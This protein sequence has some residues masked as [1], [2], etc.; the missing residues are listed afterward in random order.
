MAALVAAGGFIGGIMALTNLLKND[1]STLPQSDIEQ[2]NLTT[3]ITTELSTILPIAT[4]SP[5]TT[6]SAIITTNSS[7]ITKVEL[8]SSSNITT[9]I[10]PTSSSNMTTLPSSSNITTTLPS[11]SNITTTTTLPSSSNITTTLPSSSNITTTTTLPSSSNITTTTTLPSSSNITTTLPSSSNIT[12]TLPSSSN[13][14]TTLPSSSNITTI[15]PTSSSNMT[16]IEQTSSSNMTTIEPTSSSNMTTIEP[17]SSSNM[18]TIEPTTT[19]LPSSSNITTSKNITTTSSSNITTTTSKNITTTSS[20]NITTTT[21]KNITTTT[22]KNITTTSS[23]NITTTIK[24]TFCNNVLK[25]ADFSSPPITEHNNNFDI[26]NWEYVYGDA[27]SYDIYNNIRSDNTKN[28]LN[29]YDSVSYPNL[30]PNG[31]IMVLLFSNDTTFNNYIQ[32]GFSTSPSSLGV[33]KQGT[34]K[35]KATVLIPTFTGLP[36]IKLNIGFYANGNIINT[37]SNQSTINLSITRASNSVTVTYTTITDITI[38]GNVVLTLTIPPGSK[39][40]GQ[41]IG[42]KF[43][44]ISTVSN[45]SVFIGN[46]KMITPDSCNN[47]LL[48]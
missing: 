20:S 48:F 3:S 36:N 30:V 32:Q 25:N 37:L 17:T 13:I 16:T 6:T 45:N 35:L 18:T 41:N 31:T 26:D 19:T 9:T 42:V 46:I 40:I 27:C 44:N 24:P 47:P 12:T 38:D 14:T 5:I 8:T 21:S 1:T 28:A 22:S 23:K 10:E 11:S 34:Y 7:D 33:Y 15:E 39:L 4:T 43:K 29:P 2:P